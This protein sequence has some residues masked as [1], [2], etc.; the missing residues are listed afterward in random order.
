MRLY[1]ESMARYKSSPYLYPLNGLGELPQGFARSYYYN[2]TVHTVCL[3]SCLSTMYVCSTDVKT[4]C[5][6]RLSAE[7][8]GTYIVN[9]VVDEIVM[10]NGKVTAVKSQ[11]DVRRE[12]TAL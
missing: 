11:G 5:C 2:T 4:L 7:H 10:E 9:R 6:C 12:Q 8:G 3:S 1:L